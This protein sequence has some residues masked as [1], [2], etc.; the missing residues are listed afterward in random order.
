LRLNDQTAE[1]KPAG[2]SAP[3]ARA[4]RDIVTFG[5]AITAII[6]FVGTGGSVLPQVVRSIWGHGAAPDM[7]L[8]NAVLL[9]IALV[10]FGWRR[11]R[12][13]TVEVG[14]RRKAES[15]ARELAELDPLTGCLNRR[16]IG[17]ATDA[18]LVAN[19][20][21][22]LAT[23]FLMIDL[24]NFKQV[25]DI[26]GHAAGDAILRQ[27]AKRIS[28]ALP[29]GSLVSRFGGDEFACA[30]TFD[31]RHADRVDAL[32]ADLIAAVSQPVDAEGGSV[33][34]TISVGIA[35]NL[36]L[37]AARDGASLLHLADIAMYHAKKHGRNRAAWFEPAME[38][39]LKVR[40]ELAAGIR[41]G[42]PLGEFVPYYEKQIDLASGDLVGFEML[43]RWKSPTLGLVGPEVFIPVAEEIGMIAALSESVIAQA[44]RDA[45][46]WNPRLSLSVNISPIQLRDPWFAQKL[47]RL[48]VEANFP[49]S[50]LVIEVTESCLHEDL[51]LV[52][53]LISSLKN[54]GIKISLDDFG[55]GYSSLAQLQSL[56]FDSIKIDRSFISNLGN[57]PESTTIVEAITSLGRGLGLPITAEGIECPEILARLQELGQFNGQGYFYG[58]PQ[59]AG[60]TN[61]DLAQLDLLLEAKPEPATP[62]EAQPRARRA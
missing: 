50:R 26:N 57:S 18:L 61:D 3:L 37:G 16:S 43:A 52:R 20:E 15:Q 41:A 62:Q 44:L 9:N 34:T 22:G 5:I 12:E 4:D 1:A 8:I 27:S 13:L 36:G 11:Y 2:R 58:K 30:L 17:P 47:L 14:E 23:A 31:P 48:L 7:L 35:S 32:A 49:P 51:G 38:N 59:P 25:N 45:R 55:T 6:M 56:P 19:T 10:I 29:A 54:Q 42:V 24:D 46:H 60:V 33:E 21:R 53:S 40:S 39:E 28:A